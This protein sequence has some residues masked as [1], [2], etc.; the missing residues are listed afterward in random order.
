MST[1]TK[2]TF[3]GL[4]HIP[5]GKLGRVSNWSNDMTEGS[6]LSLD[7]SHQLFKA[8]SALVATAVLAQNGAYDKW[9]GGS[10]NF[11]S[12]HTQKAAEWKVVYIEQTLTVSEP[13][14]IPALKTPHKKWQ[15]AIIAHDLDSRELATF[16]KSHPHLL[17]PTAYVSSHSSGLNIGDTFVHGTHI[18]E[19]LDNKSSSVKPPTWAQEILVLGAVDRYTKRTVVQ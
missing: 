7:E 3:Y 15:G 8:N 9:A 17:H 12:I 19:V 16:A 6:D 2:E 13:T 1:S 14:T 4:K 10:E 18:F 5:T 11:P